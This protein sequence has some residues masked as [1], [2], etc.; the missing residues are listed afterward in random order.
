MQTSSSPLRRY[1]IPIGLWFFSAYLV[2]TIV[3][4][5]AGISATIGLP[6]FETGIE[7]A[8]LQVNAYAALLLATQL[9][10]TWLLC[11]N[12]EAA[13]FLVFLVH[14]AISIAGTVTVTLIMGVLLYIIN[15][16]G[17]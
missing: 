7:Q 6:Q 5:V 17:Q 10:I 2:G 11:R 13:G 8:K 12:R 15:L 9:V 16:M 14:L 1:A 3:G 4:K